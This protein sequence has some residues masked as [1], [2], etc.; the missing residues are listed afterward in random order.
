MAHEPPR[1]GARRG[2]AAR[3]ALAGIAFLLAT[4]LAETVLRA[5]QAGADAFCVWTPGID[6]VF[7]PAPGVMAGIEG[8]SRFRTSSLGLR[9][10]E[11]EPAD[12]RR[13]LCLGG[14]TTECLYLDQDE[15]WPARLEAAWNLAQPGVGTW[16]GN[17]G[18]SGRTTRDHVV[19]MRYLPEEIPELDLLLLLPGAND[20]TLRLARDDAYDPRFLERP[21]AEVTLLPRAFEQLPLRLQPAPFY[22]RTATWRM[23]RALKRRFFE[24][25]AQD[26][27]GSSYVRWRANRRAAT[28]WRDELPP[29]ESALDEFERNLRTI[30]DECRAHGIELVLLTQP[31]AWRADLP[32]GF[33]PNL[34]MGWVGPSQEVVGQPY[35]TPAALRRGLDRYNAATRAVAAELGLLLV[36]LAAEMDGDVRWFYDDVHFDE[37]GAE[38]VAEL[39]A[40][41]LVR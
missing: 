6:T 23:A 26:S 22:K 3:L 30:A 25:R 31:A 5:G 9:A 29:L 11:L 40:A 36:D 20:L 16:V 39:L 41:A 35:Y 37:A 28:A 27:A 24:R 38:R 2:R 10:R 18:V 4:L 32:P 19:V 15:T 12:V 8:D 34:W 21:D 33:E 7:R 14:S 17:A 13:V 1:R